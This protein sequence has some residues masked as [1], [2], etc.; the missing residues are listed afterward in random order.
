MEM[1]HKESGKVI[2]VS[3]EHAVNVLIPQGKYEPLEDMVEVGKQIVA[4][5]DSLEGRSINDE[6]TRKQLMEMLD[7]KEVIY[8]PT[9]K[10]ADLLEMVQK[11]YN[12]RVKDGNI[13]GDSQ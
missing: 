4:E 11:A 13:P 9:E 6:V 8:R 7:K 3:F 1:K 5:D 10:K 12:I 2:D